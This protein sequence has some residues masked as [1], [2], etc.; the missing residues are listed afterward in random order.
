MLKLRGFTLIELLTAMTVVGILVAAGGP[1]LIQ[2]V[3]DSRVR[4]AA[5]GWRDGLAQARVEAIRRNQ[6]VTFR[7]VDDS[8]AY[9]IV[10]LDDEG[11]EVVLASWSGDGLDEAVAVVLDDEVALDYD[12]RGVAV[13]TGTTFRADFSSSAAEC[14]A[15]G[16]DAVCLA[17]E[18]ASGFVK[19]CDP[20]AAGDS[21]KACQI[22][23]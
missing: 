19:V 15:D 2:T 14:I 23:D 13:P 8:V 10:A 20:A 6:R 9:E 7:P 17:V 4:G 5:E 18:A 11:E 16:G 3:R 1:A 12:G 22:E 21:P